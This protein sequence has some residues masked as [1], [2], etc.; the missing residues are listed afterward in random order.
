MY[1]R[2]AVEAD[3]EGIASVHVNSWKTTYRGIVDDAYLN[4]LSVSD[5]EERWRW[6]IGNLRDDEELLVVADNQGTIYGFMTYGREREDKLPHEGEVYAVYL[7][8]EIQGQGWGSR[9]FA[10]MKKFLRSKGFTSLMV[11]VL[12]GNSALA[13]YQRMGGRE[14][15]RKEI[16]IGGKTYTEFALKW[17]SIEQLPER[18]V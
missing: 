14:I 9:L 8:K 3:A 4:S 13:F 16:E 6:K 17:D 12:E 18:E 5:R 15:K 2:T 1:I 11:W 10:R 7:L